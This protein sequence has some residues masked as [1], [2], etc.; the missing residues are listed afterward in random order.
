MLQLQLLPL[1]VPLPKPAALT[2]GRA[3]HAADNLT[4]TAISKA[5]RD[6]RRYRGIQLS[7]GLRTVLVSDPDAEMTAASVDVHVGSWSDPDDLP[8]LAHFCEHMLFMSSTKCV[9]LPLAAPPRPPWADARARLARCR[10][11][12]GAHRPALA[13]PAAG[14]RRR[15]AT[16]SS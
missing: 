2:P 13:P 3:L 16:R 9:A 10:G 15:T 11:G 4:V 14:T 8:G 5:E 1:A 7:N 6:K 12:G